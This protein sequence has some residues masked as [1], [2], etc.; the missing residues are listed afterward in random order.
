MLSS[1]SAEGWE[2]SFIKYNG[3]RVYKVK[4]HKNTIVHTKF[5]AD[6]KIQSYNHTDDD[7]DDDRFDGSNID[8]FIN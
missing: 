6:L 1:V 8:F 7:D 3:P 5:S 4:D 2:G